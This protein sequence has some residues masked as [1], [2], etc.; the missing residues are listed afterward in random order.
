MIKGLYGV[1][2]L[3]LYRLIWLATVDDAIY[4]VIFFS[5]WCTH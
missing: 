2:E 5:S 3:G 4:Q 1:L